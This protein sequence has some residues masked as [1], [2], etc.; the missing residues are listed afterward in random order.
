MI[1]NI[2][3]LFTAGPFDLSNPYTSSGIERLAGCTNGGQFNFPNR[4]GWSFDV[5]PTPGGGFGAG[6]GYTWR[7]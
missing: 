1:I 3:S 7:F 4:S 5:F 2:V 6:V